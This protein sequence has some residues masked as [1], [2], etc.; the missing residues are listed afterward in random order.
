MPKSGR[1]RA[2]AALLILLVCP[3]SL[4]GQASAADEA[5][6]AGDTLLC[7]CGCH[8]QSVNDC[9]CGRAAEMRE[10]IAALVAEGLSSDEVVAK[11]VASSGEQIRIVPTADHFN[12]VAWLGPFVG[13]AAGGVW[14]GFVLRRWQR[15]AAHHE[16]P[17]APAPA[18]PNVDPYMARL[19][20]EL[21]ELE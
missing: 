14:L 1:A 16:P 9:A 10:E 21:R 6:I 12:L 2:A 15:R 8:P 13:L 7:D 19:E 20:R 3:A 17:T 5:R 11:Y 18:K 4:L